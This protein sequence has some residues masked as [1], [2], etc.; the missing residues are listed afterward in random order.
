MTGERER[1]RESKSISHKHGRKSMTE[2]AWLKKH[3]RKSMTEKSWLKK[4][5]RKSITKNV[6]QKNYYPNRGFVEICFAN[7]KMSVNETLWLQFEETVKMVNLLK[8]YFT[9]LLL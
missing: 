7:L 8:K 4:H 2:I 6:W 1:Q 9:L 5:D 3:D